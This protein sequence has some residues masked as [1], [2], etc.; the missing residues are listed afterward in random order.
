MPGVTRE[1]CRR[2][3]L[4][5]RL[6]P[7]RARFALNPDVIYLDGN[8]LGPPPKTVEDRLARLIREEWAQ[9][10]VRSWTQAHWIDAP[11]RVGAKI[12]PLIG[13]EADEVIVADS[14]SANIFKLLCAA[15]ALNPDRRTLLSEAGSFPT[16]VYMMEGLARISGGRLRRALA[17]RDGLLDRIDDDTAV[18]LLTHIH[19]KTGEM[20]DMAATTRAAREKG[21]RVIWDLSHSA[22]AMPLDIH[23][24]GADFAV[25]CGYKFLNGGP[26]APAFLYCAERHLSAVQPV[27][28]GWM[29]HARPFDFT[30]DYRPAP[31]TGRFLCGTPP[32]LSLAALECGIDTFGDVDLRACRVK[33]MALGQLFIKLAAP[34]EAQFGLRLASPRDPSVRG[35]QVSFRHEHA[36]PICRA[37]IDRGVIGDF[38]AP[39]IL[40]FGLAA[41]Y[42][43]FVDIFDAA[44]ALRAVLETRAWESEAYKTRS[45][46]T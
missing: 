31:G 5:D 39:D 9:G 35:A 44:A 46:V 3:D 26:G 41:P 13:A 34:L 45:A 19:Y 43:Y 38:R 36:Y 17:P 7:L 40:R 14:T 1:D 32:I 30:D 15:A 16:D 18:L 25:G 12:A 42:T 27:L 23:A 6:A 28:S 24:S 4:E 11:R 37:L 10:L 29:G 33:S 2:L 8:S 20:W 21:A 22:G